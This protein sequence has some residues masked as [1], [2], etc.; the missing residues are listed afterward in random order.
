MLIS[1]HARS[2]AA[3]L[4]ATDSQLLQRIRQILIRHLP[5]LVPP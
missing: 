4:A 1:R 3:P 5:G 2:F